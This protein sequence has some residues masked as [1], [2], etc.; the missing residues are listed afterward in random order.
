MRRRFFFLEPSKVRSY[1]ITLIEGY[2]RALR[3]SEDM[4]ARFDIIV[5]LSQ[6]TWSYLP[7]E[8]T[9]GIRHETIPVVDQDEHKVI[10]KSLLEFAVVLK[11]VLRLRRHDVLFVSCL[12][13]PALLLIELANVF[14]RRQ[15]VFVVVH[16]EM[17]AVLDRTH[18][19]WRSIGY[20]SRRWLSIRPRSSRIHVVVIDD[21]I[22]DALSRKHPEK[23]PASAVLVIHHPIS[24]FQPRELEHT[25]YSTVCFIGYRSPAKG[26]D[27]FEQ[28]G[29]SLPDLQFLAI[30]GGKV[31]DVRTG[32]K[33]PI[34]GGAGFLEAIYGCSVALFPYASSY[35]CSLSAAA[36]D[37]LSTGVHIV[38]TPLP[39]F[40]SLYEGL[41]PQ[42]VTIYRS[43]D[44]LRAL[45]SNLEFLAAIEAGRLERIRRLTTSPFGQAEVIRDFEHIV[46]FVDRPLNTRDW[47]L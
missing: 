29:R 34:V 11:Y 21:F 8:V 38:A 35:N 31:E 18:L 33:T 46:E 4:K 32:V 15:N 10:R 14:L 45:L 17:E 44:E 27:L 7:P 47:Y 41:G 26:F 30:G 28:L 16:G 39:F 42:Y 3:A 5:S 24:E 22:R 36:I 9:N 37:A 43:I 12:V 1:H 20:W 6:S 2:L 40:V 13:P 19:D 25:K 23:L